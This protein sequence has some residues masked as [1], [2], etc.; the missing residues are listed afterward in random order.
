MRNAGEEL[1][2]TLHKRGKI[3][4]QTPTASQSFVISSIEC[5]ILIKSASI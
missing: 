1:E 4:D 3:P 5:R 2:Q